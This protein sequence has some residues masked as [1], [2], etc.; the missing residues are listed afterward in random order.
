MRHDR[1]GLDP[2]FAKPL[3]DVC[4]LR[5]RKSQPM[6]AGVD[7]NPG[8]FQWNVEFGAPIEL[9]RLMQDG[10]EVELA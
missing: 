2:R 5:W 10:P 9:L 1:H 3:F 8:V 7:F 6:H 4:K